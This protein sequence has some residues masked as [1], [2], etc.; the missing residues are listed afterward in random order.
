MAITFDGASI[1]KSGVSGPYH[2]TN[3]MLTDESVDLLTEAV[4]ADLG[5]T[6]AYDYHTFQH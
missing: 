4:A 2:V 3:V 1:Y 5:A 6:K